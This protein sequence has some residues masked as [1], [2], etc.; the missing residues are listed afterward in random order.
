MKL[1]ADLNFNP[2]KFNLSYL[3]EKKHIGDQEYMKAK[4]NLVE[5]SFGYFLLKQK[6]I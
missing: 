2:I 4:I 3:Q 1:N 6:E 5:N